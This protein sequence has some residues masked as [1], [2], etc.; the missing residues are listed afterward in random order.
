MSGAAGTDAPGTDARGRTP[1]VL[2]C[3]EDAV[4]V[5]LA[6]LDGVSA[7]ADVLRTDPPPGVV[8][9]VPAARTVLVRGDVRR[10]A[11]W[12]AA[13]TRAAVAGPA[14]DGPAAG[15]RPTGRV[16]DIPVVYD[17][18]DLAQV[19]RATGLSVEEVV[20][21]HLAGGPGGYRVA[22]GGFA[23]G[24]AYVVGVDPR[25]HVPRLATPRTRVPAG[26]VALAGDYTA[27]YPA[28][29]PGGWQLLG[30]TSVAMFDVGRGRDAAALL[31]P[32]DVVRFVPAPAVPRAVAAPRAAPPSAA[33]HAPGRTVAQDSTVAPD[34]T[35]APGSPIDPDSQVAPDSPVAPPSP[36]APSP[37]VAPPS[38]V[39][40]SPPVAP[41]SPV[42]PSPPVAP[43]AGARAVTVLATGP[44]L[45]LQDL[46]RPGLAAVGVPRSGAAD[47]DALRRANRLVGNRPSAA[48]LEVVLGGLVLRCTATTAL[49]LT[50]APVAA[51]LD[52]A[53]VPHGAAIRA[54]AGAVLR[55][56]SPPE[57]L[58]TW[59]AVRG[60]LAVPSVLGSRSADVLSGLGP[61]AVRQGDVLP[62]GDD[63]DG[64]PEPALPDGPVPAVEVHGVEVHGVAIPGVAVPGVAGPDVEVPG[65][66]LLPAS[67]GPR[68]DHLDARGR[69][70]LWATVWDVSPASN[71]VAVRLAGAPLMR[72]ALGELPSE[73]LVAGAVQVPPDG[74]PVVF[75]ADHP[76]TGGYPVV[77]VLT[78]EGRARAAQLRPGQR[79]RLTRTDVPPI[80]PS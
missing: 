70:A 13:V 73:G 48:G 36:V 61:A 38:P 52:G 41:P 56:G 46:G 72:R 47:P 10:R 59:V 77:A 50:G 76:V 35:V 28:A 21:R 79:V 54:P 5:E 16:V 58:R 37:P 67:D 30:T 40:P 53:A 24:F 63:V 80:H 64:L 14:A 22:F 23:P 55:L 60:G 69:A 29:S 32:G 27:V 43:H 31:R 4:L 78:R 8:D 57:G 1:R 9:V 34:N 26:A 6:D 12:L 3:G 25:L 75:G 7:L 11:V 65:H 74:Q 71:R 39:A 42:A 2:P 51:D 20:A 33:P 45:L 17:G 62:L 66:V 19:A 44:L 15:D 18:P 68:L 49:A